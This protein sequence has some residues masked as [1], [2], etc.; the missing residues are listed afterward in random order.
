MR[1]CYLVDMKKRKNNSFKCEDTSS[2]KIE[3]VELESQKKMQ[4]NV[5][6][7]KKLFGSDD[8]LLFLLEN[9]PYIQLIII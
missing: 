7:K 6:G 5:V 2:K 1:K 4:E 9:T 3:N 8:H